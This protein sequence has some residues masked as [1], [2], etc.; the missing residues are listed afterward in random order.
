[1]KRG[2]WVAQLGVSFLVVAILARGAWSAP[3]GAA[4]VP[5]I[6]SFGMIKAHSGDSQRIF[7]TTDPIE[8]QAIYHD[9]LPACDGVAPT[10]VQLFVFT[11]EGR[12]I[13]QF[14][15]TSSAGFDSQSR[16][17][18]RVL[19]AGSL[20]IGTYKFTFL[21]RDCTNNKSVVQPELLTF[22]VIA[23]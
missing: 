20:A 23:P 4:N 22:R 11:A 13:G 15:G 16:P 8:F 6:Q 12:F 14:D 10:F 3:T 9:P 7:R 1:M 18:D 2:V 19:V 17:L 5:Q 21:V